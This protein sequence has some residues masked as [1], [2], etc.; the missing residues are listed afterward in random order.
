MLCVHPNAFRI[1]HL[2]KPIA[3]GIPGENFENSRFPNYLSAYRNNSTY[4]EK[5]CTHQLSPTIF[6]LK[7]K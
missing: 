3:D 6:I 4:T 2:I 1:I 5:M 7:L